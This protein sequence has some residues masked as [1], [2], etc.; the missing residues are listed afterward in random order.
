M[1]Y[2]VV[3]VGRLIENKDPLR[4]IRVMSG[5]R[6]RIPGVKAA[7]IGMVLL[8]SCATML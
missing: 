3:F 2:D 1:A 4:F 8:L 5:V 7:I 6:A